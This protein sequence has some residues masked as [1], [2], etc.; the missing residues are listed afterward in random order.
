VGREER[1]TI[2][3]QV[4]SG[5]W[6]LYQSLMTETLLRQDSGKIKK[7][8]TDQALGIWAKGVAEDKRSHLMC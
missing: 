7:T 8:T 4:L 2:S 5:F 1:Q 3:W 6:T